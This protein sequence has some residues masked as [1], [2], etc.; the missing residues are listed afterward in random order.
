MH[1]GEV[2]QRKS[3]A[4]TRNILQ[5]PRSDSNPSLSPESNTYAQVQSISLGKYLK[6]AMILT[7]HVFDFVAGERLIHDV[8]FG[9][10]SAV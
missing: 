6:L 10:V 8:E 9:H 7:Y 3:D 5:G 1:L 4:L 2:R